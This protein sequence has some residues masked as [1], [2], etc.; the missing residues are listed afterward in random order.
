MPRRSGLVPP[1]HGLSPGS[2]RQ[3]LQRGAILALLAALT[4]AACAPRIVPAQVGV[5]P[6]PH[7]TDRR[8][9][10]WARREANLVVVRESCRTAT[11]Y[12]RGEWVQTFRELSFGR[13][14][15]D[16]LHEGDK[17]TPLGLYRIAAGRRHARWARFLLLDYPNLRDI[18]RTAEARA[19]GRIHAGTGGS[20]GIHGTDSPLLNRAAVDWTLGCISLQNQDVIELERLVPVGTPVVV[21]P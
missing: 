7:V 4:L 16:K 19:A 18:E 14:E 6:L 20:I 12:R 10:E 1:G 8:P 5:G 11:V 3:L 17:R 9:L 2:S 21:L 15:G 13:T